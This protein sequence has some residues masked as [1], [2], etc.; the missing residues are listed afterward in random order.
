MSQEN[1]RV[2]SEMVDAFERRDLD[3][4]LARISSGVEWDVSEGFLGVQDVYRGWT[5]VRKW[6]ND[7]LEAWES[8][9][10]EIDEIAE[11]QAGAVFVGINGKGRGSASGVETE[12]HFLFVIWVADHE[13]A[14][15]RMFQSRDEALEA[16][17]LSE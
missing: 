14:R 3:G 7:F 15:L 11:G 8:F 12:H 1:L 5:G 13:V 17:G 6:W 10:A 4:Y 9:D 16:A 2:V